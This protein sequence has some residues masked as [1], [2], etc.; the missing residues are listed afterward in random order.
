M[1]VTFR[2][3]CGGLR[4]EAPPHGAGLSGRQRFEDGSYLMPQAL[5][6][7]RSCPCGERLHSQYH[8]VRHHGHAGRGTS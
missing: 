6:E 7:C 1:K 2:C 3:Q 8:L 5:G 4:Y